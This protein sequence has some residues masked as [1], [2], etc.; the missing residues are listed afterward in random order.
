MEEKDSFLLVKFNEFNSVGFQ[1]SMQN[2]SPLQL[3]ALGEYLL[4]K[5]K[6]ALHIQEETAMLEK[7]KQ[8]EQ[9][10]IAVPT[11]SVLRGK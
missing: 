8:E 9:T 11:S 6:S 7:V 2:T 4:Y 3:L 10:K 1:L 5:G